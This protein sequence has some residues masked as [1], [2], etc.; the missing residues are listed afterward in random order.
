M[1]G[2]FKQEQAAL[3]NFTETEAQKI[4]TALRKNGIVCQTWPQEA[5]GQRVGY[6][7]GMGGFHRLP[8][9]E[10]VPFPLDFPE[11][12]L[13]LHHVQRK[14]LDK[15]L[16]RLREAGV[17]PIRFKAVTT[18]YNVHWTLAHLVETMRKEHAYMMERE[19]KE[20]EKQAGASE[21]EAQST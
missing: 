10:D 1:A 2:R 12:V 3:Y 7:F 21:A 13:L 8:E 15:A 16:D 17:P 5:W 14:A 20:A 11:G 19:A 6:L 18:P 4:M 9:S